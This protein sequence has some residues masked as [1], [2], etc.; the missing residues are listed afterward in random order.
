[1]KTEEITENMELDKSDFFRR[2][3]IPWYDSYPVCWILIL[4]AISIL[5]FAL[6]GMQIA[7]TNESLNDYIWFPALLA[8]LAFMMFLSLVFRIIYRNINR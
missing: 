8:V 6:T 7:I 2:I 4:W 5:M 3:I 1:M